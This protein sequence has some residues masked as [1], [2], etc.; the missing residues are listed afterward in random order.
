MP[1]KD[2]KNYYAPII[3]KKK[4]FWQELAANQSPDSKT[5]EIIESS[6][7]DYAIVVTDTFVWIPVSMTWLNVLWTI[8]CPSLHRRKG[9][10]FRWRTCTG[11][12]LTGFCVGIEW[13]LT[14]GV[15]VCLGDCRLLLPFAVWSRFLYSFAT[16]FTSN[17]FPQ[18]FLKNTEFVFRS[19]FLY[20]GIR[21]YICCFRVVHYIELIAIAAKPFSHLRGEV[22][23]F[24]YI[25]WSTSL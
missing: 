6:T 23:I 20:L 22:I 17:Q 24:Y 15:I 12:Q 19:S 5:G 3:F 2:F 7:L 9:K 4:I 10:L 14:G 16:L 11:C 13:E 1:K 8:V 25:Y 21:S 18:A